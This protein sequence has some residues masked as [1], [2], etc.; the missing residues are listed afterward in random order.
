MPFRKTAR[1]IMKRRPRKRLGLNKVEKK[2]VK[3]II[4]KQQE[5]KFLDYTQTISSITSSSA[6]NISAGYQIDQGDGEGQRIGNQLSMKGI[7]Y[8]HIITSSVSAVLRHLIIMTPLALAGSDLQTALSAVGVNDFL[9]RETQKYK[10]LKD[11]NYKLI[12]SLV[13][14]GPAKLHL[15]GYI[16]L[17]GRKQVFDGDTG[18]D[19]QTF[20]II[21]Y[22]KS[23]N[24][25]ASVLSSD[26]V[27]RSFYKDA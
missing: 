26:N 16:N 17:K 6:G 8:N 9:P 13:T 27:Y 20:Q 22:F 15:K 18:S 25:T 2:Q 24:A 23:D 1:K 5:S 11:K 14:T 12:P 19:Y 7:G 21:E 4:S 10:V 3:K